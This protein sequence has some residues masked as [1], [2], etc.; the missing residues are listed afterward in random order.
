MP[1]KLVS[2]Y[3]PGIT[4]EAIQSHIIHEKHQWWP[5]VIEKPQCTGRLRRYVI[6]RPLMAILLRQMWY[7]HVDKWDEITIWVWWTDWWVYGLKAAT[8]GRW[9]AVSA[10]IW[11][12]KWRLR[13]HAEY[14]SKVRDQRT[15]DVVYIM[16][17]GGTITSVCTG[18]D[19]GDFTC[20]RWQQSTFKWSIS[21]QQEL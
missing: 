8:E 17:Y 10:A 15:F 13:H 21:E 11:L 9:T 19:T 1:V 7:F 12:G 6:R 20:I 16:W 3:S 2:V 14:Q 4:S 5:A 18:L